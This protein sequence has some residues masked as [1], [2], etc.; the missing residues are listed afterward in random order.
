MK[1]ALLLISLLFPLYSIADIT[2][3]KNLYVGSISAYNERTF[4]VFKSA[5]ASGSG[6]YAQNFDGW[7]PEDKNIAIS[8][9]LASKMSG[10]RVNISTNSEKGCGIHGTDT[11]GEAGAGRTLNVV[12]MANLP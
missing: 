4:V 11:N 8:L 5:E 6:S 10:H 12:Q 2:D 1:K 9:L 7:N 3:C